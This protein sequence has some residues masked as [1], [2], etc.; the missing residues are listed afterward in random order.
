VEDFEQWRA[1]AREHL[2]T[3]AETTRRT[4]ETCVD[5]ILRAASLLAES[6]QQGH[7]TLICGNGGSAADAQHIAAELVNTL[8]KNLERPGLPAIA[9][10]TDTSF[11][12]A[13]ANDYGYDGA[14]E[15]QVLALGKPGDVLI[16][17]STSGNSSNVI[18]AVAAAQDRGMKVIGLL[19]EGGKL[20]DLVDQA[21]VVPS[22]D[23][24]HVQ[25]AL[26]VVEH[27]ICLLVETALFR[28]NDE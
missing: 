12:T 21:V 5:S 17:I 11:L 24:Q 20:I 27:A 9:L 7:K 26:L 16:G 10:T 25:E 22:R 8:S 6:F 3:G 18:R 28:Q 2:L 13:Y 15:R 4:A 1:L 14:F 19:G 23:T